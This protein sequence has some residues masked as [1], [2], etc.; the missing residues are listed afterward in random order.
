MKK[1][2]LACV[3]AVGLASPVMA[4]QCPMDLSKIESA[5]K[6]AKLDDATK[7]KVTELF[8]K[9]KAEHDAGKHAESVATLAEAKKILG[10]S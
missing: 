2:A 3:I 9:G 10:I 6:T 4:G 7:K 8:N 5:M 1:L